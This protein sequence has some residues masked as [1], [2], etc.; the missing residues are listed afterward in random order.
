M[1]KKNPYSLAAIIGVLAVLVM[2]WVSMELNQPNVSHETSGDE[3][4]GRS[5]PPVE[6]LP[7]QVNIAGSNP[8]LRKIEAPKSIEINLSANTI[9]L[10]QDGKSVGTLPIA[11]QAKE[12]KWFQTPTGY[13]RIG[14][15]RERHV[16]SLTGVIMPYSIQLYEDFYIHQIP[17]FKNGEVVTS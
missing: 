9:N 13:F 5:Q 6:R 12:G 17:F 10:W 1:V 14:E 16:S 8:A 4:S 3:A 11:Y 7:L 15:K 2:I